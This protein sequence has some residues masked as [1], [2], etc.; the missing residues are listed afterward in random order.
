[1]SS[2]EN[3]CALL[4]GNFAALKAE[5]GRANYNAEAAAANLVALQE[6]QKALAVALADMVMLKGK[7]ADANTELS[8]FQ[9]PQG[10]S[11]KEAT[12]GDPE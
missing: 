9:R 5:H 4:C 6:C 12:E 3:N 11:W 1:M 8:Y 10:M 2:I 7:L